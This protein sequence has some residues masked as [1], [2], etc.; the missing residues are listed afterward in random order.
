[1]NKTHLLNYG[2]DTWCKKPRNNKTNW[3]LVYNKNDRRRFYADKNSCK[4][5]VKKLKEL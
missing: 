1:M 5:C 2:L 3:T 4:T